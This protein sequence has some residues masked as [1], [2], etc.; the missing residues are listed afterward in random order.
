M[1]IGKCNYTNVIAAA[2]DKIYIMTPYFI[3]D[4]AILELL[5]NQAQ[6]GVD[7]RIVLLGIPDKE[8]VYA[9]SRGNA[10]RL[11]ENGVKV[12][13]VKN[14]FVHRK[15]MLNEDCA[16]VGSIKLD[17]HSFYQQFECAVFTDDMGVLRDMNMDFEKAFS[18]CE[19]ITVLNTKR[20]SILNRIYVGVLQLFAPIM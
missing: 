14:A 13:C 5:I 8:I 7:V 17:L 6:S 12:Y 3:P 16:V 20:K 18:D 15:I 4:S 1:N 9:V 10:E 19:Q 11:I 2:K